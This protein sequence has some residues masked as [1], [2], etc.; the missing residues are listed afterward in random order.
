MTNPFAP[1]GQQA[2]PPQQAPPQQPPAQ[3][4][5][6]NQF[7]QGGGQAP[8]QQPPA[9]APPQQPPP[10]QGGNQGGGQF[11]QPSRGSGD[12]VTADEWMSWTGCLVLFECH[13]YRTDM[14]TKNT[15][16][17]ETTRAV[18]ADV[19]VIDVNGGP[20]FKDR[21]FVF[22]P[23]LVTACTEAAK[24]GN[25]AKVLGRINRYQTQAGRETVELAEHTQQD[26]QTAAN[27]LTW[28]AAQNMGQPAATQQPQQQQAAPQ[29]P[30]AQQQ[31]GQW[32]VGN[33]APP[34]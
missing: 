19:H 5:G 12:T 11:G 31:Q 25:G 17:G 26:A 33:E 6:G 2:P 20:I 14:I 18:L 32:Q 23:A 8:P 1:Q 15:K 10:Q 21:V 7:A 30:P 24:S 4:Q 16:P 29:Q 9:Q 27:Y 28:R 13:E 34:F 3:P 22:P